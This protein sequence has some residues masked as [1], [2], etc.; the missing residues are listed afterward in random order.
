MKDVA[1]IPWRPRPSVLKQPPSDAELV[2]WWF[3][4]RGRQNSLVVSRCLMVF[5]TNLQFRSLPLVRPE[6]SEAKYLRDI[7]DACEVLKRAGRWL[8]TFPN[9]GEPMPLLRFLLGEKSRSIRLGR[10][11]RRR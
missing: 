8:L 7:D 10:L 3:V 1:R 5:K 2:Y 9:W 11:R 6:D 4:A